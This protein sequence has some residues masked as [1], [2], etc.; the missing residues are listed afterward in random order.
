M[1][2]IVIIFFLFCILFEQINCQ[3]YIADFALYNPGYEDDGVWQEEV[4]ALEAIFFT[5]EWSYKTIDHNDINNGELI[6]GNN[7]NY[8]A[9]IAPGGWAF[10]RE[11]VVNPLGE[12]HIH[13]FINSGGNFIG[14]C[15]GAYWATDTVSWAQN[16]SGENGMFNQENDYIEY[17]Y[18]LNLLGAIAKG[19]FGWTP[20]QNGDTASLQM[21]DINRQNATMSLIEMP[22][23]TSFF[24]YGGPFS[25]LRSPSRKYFDIITLSTL[26][27]TSIS[28]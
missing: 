27:L 22:D 16:G 5:Y 26:L 4:T 1:I 23:S 20:W 11:I 14:F 2:R 21:A 6:D 10:N 12:N 13:N 9:L 8:K 15:A 7:L 24:Y 25:Q 3:N 18:N 19:P 17:D 28:G